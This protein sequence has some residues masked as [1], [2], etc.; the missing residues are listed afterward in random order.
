MVIIAI[1]LLFLVIAVILVV[2]GVPLI[3]CLIVSIWSAA[4]I[5]QGAVVLRKQQGR[6][7]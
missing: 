5:G 3:I 1:S 7:R 4:G 2:L 6:G